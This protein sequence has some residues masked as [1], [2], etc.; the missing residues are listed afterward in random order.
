[1]SYREFLLGI[2]DEEAERL[3]EEAILAGAVDPDEIHLVEDDLVDDYL[4]GRLSPEE[5]RGFTEHFLS[6]AERQQKLAFVRALMQ[7]ARKQPSGENEKSQRASRPVPWPVSVSWRITTA[8]ALAASLILAGLLGHQLALL[9]REAQ[10]ARASQNEVL[11]LQAALAAVKG[12]SSQP[13]QT[14][15]SLPPSSELQSRPA[16]APGGAPLLELAPGLTRGGQKAAQI[17]LSY[18]TRLVWINLQLPSSP[19]HSYRE[20]LIAESGERLWMQVFTTA[21]STGANTSTIALPAALLPSGDYLIRLEEA[22]ENG[23]FEETASY[24]FRV[25]R[26]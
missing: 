5:E 19:S 21:S 20:E 1:M 23:V 13:G 2:S 4:F 26:D 18:G 3:I 24:P 9:R 11:Q 8:V 7:Y 16:S 17:H 6:T 25:V 14:F 12:G 15:N 22:S 10:V